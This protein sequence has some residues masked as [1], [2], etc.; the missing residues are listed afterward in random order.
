M[1]PTGSLKLHSNN[2]EGVKHCSDDNDDIDDEENNDESTN[3]DSKPA[4]LKLSQ[5]RELE[6]GTLGRNISIAR[7]RTISSQDVKSKQDIHDIEALI[8]S[9][10]AVYVFFLPG[11][12]T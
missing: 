1:P 10:L 12:I 2:I 9:K 8:R 3:D 11:S 7:E 4:K 6:T 5:I